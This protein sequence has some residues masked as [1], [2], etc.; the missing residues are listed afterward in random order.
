MPYQKSQTKADFGELQR[1]FDSLK[2]TALHWILKVSE[3]RRT[4]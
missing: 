1:T 2:P 3:R 4:N